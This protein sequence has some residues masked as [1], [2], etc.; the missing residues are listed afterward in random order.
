MKI[1]KKIKETIIYAEEWAAYFKMHAPDKFQ[2]F[3][4]FLDLFLVFTYPIGWIFQILVKVFIDLIHYISADLKKYIIEYIS[5]AFESPFL[6]Y[7]CI[8]YKYF[9]K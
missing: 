8:K 7:F 4:F 9:K 5:D 6:T 1:I 2:W 3:A